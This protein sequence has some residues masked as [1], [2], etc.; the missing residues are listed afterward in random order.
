MKET[1][2][3]YGSLKFKTTDKRLN[4]LLIKYSRFLCEAY[5]YGRLYDLGLY[6]AL[7][8]HNKNLKVFGKLLSISHGD[9][10]FPYLDRYEG[11]DYR[12]AA[13]NVYDLKH[14][15][16]IAWVYTYSKSTSFLPRIKTGHYQQ[17]RQKSLT[18]LP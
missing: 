7:V 2:F 6:P 15:P 14:A 9:K 17:K 8:H 5:T 13:I 12:R 1:L 4:Y 16:Q 3:I 18:G 10:I 11:I